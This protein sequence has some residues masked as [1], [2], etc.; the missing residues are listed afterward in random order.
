MFPLGE[1]R[2]LFVQKKDG[3]IRMCIDYHQLNKM[4]IKNGY[5]L[6][7]IG[8]LFDHVGGAKIFLKID[9]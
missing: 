4:T 5:P 9:L 6:P 1:H 2:F 7:R 8:D 3:M